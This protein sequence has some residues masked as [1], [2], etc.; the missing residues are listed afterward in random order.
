M[1]EVP[2]TKTTPPTSVEFL[3]EDH[4]PPAKRLKDATGEP[5][6][7]PSGVKPTSE[8]IMESPTSPAEAPGQHDSKPGGPDAAQAR[9]PKLFGGLTQRQA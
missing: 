2:A 7:L 3:N 6:T 8:A 9:K 1:S 4:V 5:D